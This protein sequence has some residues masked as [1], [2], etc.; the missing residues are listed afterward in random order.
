MPR[1]TIQKIMLAIAL[2]GASMCVVKNLP[3]GIRELRCATHC[4]TRLSAVARALIEYQD[5]HQIFPSGTHCNTTLAYEDR[6]S[7]YAEILPHLDNED[8]GALVNWDQPWNGGFNDK[9]SRTG[10]LSVVCENQDRGLG[11]P[12]PVSYIGIAGFGSDA[13]LLSKTDWRAGV[14]GFDRVTS[15]AD[16]KDGAANTMMLAESTR[17][18]S[19]WLQGGP[20]TVRGLDPAKQPY[21]GV[22]RPFGGLHKGRACIAMADGSV[23]WV[24][25]SISPKVF[26]AIATMA[27]GE[28]LPA[29]W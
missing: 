10:I 9:L 19:S 2:V 13:P 14:F 18:G 15:S 23:R 8:I 22:N 24:S 26:E 11:G 7:W 20:A 21:L 17:I 1:I 16:I 28:R 3:S 27:G 12:W 5:R 25:D 4:F 29:E 6:L